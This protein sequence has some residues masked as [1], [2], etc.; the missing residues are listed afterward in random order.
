MGKNENEV[1]FLGQIYTLNIDKNATCVNFTNCFMIYLR[2]ERIMRLK[3]VEGCQMLTVLL[4]LAGLCMI[5]T[6]TPLQ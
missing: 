2:K 5:T 1:E 3:I 4:L 6:G